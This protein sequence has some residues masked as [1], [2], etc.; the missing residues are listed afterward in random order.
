MTSAASPVRDADWLRRHTAPGWR[1]AVEDVTTAYAVFGLMGPRSRRLLAGLTSADLGPDA[2]PFATSRV[3]DLGPAPRARHPD[4]L[5]RRAGLGAHR[6]HRARHRG[7]G[8]AGRRRRRGL[9]LAGYYAINALRLDKGYRAF[10]AELGPTAP[11][12][13]PG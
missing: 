5:R 9:R 6:A 10:G 7:V 11:R 8:P 4:D 12:S 1:V 13:R 3:V 2:F